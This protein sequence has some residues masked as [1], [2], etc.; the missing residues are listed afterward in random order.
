MG[1]AQ[2]VC[3]GTGTNC[4]ILAP[5]DYDDVISDIGL[6]GGSSILG[7]PPNFVASLSR[8]TRFQALKLAII[9]RIPSQI[10]PHTISTYAE[11]QRRDQR[12]KEH[13]FFT[14][15]CEAACFDIPSVRCQGVR[16]SLSYNQV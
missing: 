15:L 14:Y 1:F 2:I 4:L 3:G 6:D 16:L 8:L 10:P 11:H 12:H 5:E 7:F 13:C 9:I